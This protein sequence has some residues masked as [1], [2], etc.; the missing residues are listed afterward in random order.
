[1]L[2]SNDL[3][4]QRAL[5]RGRRSIAGG[6]YH[7]TTATYARMPCFRDFGSACAAAASINSWESLRDSRVLA[8]VLM[9]DHLHMLLEVTAPDTLSSLTGRIKARSAKS[10][11]RSS[12][13]RRVIWAKGYHDHAVRREEDIQTIARYIVANPVRA[14]LVQRCADYPFWDAIWLP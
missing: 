10:V 3:P 11:Q 14:G 1:M 13:S 9:P 7:V 5:R 2:P 12:E 6:I 8:W 4:G